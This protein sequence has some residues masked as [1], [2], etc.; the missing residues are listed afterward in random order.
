MS[1]RIARLLEVVT[2]PATGENFVTTVTGTLET[3]PL[4][5]RW[6]QNTVQNKVND[7]ITNR[8]KNGI[9]KQ[10]VGYVIYKYGSGYGLNLESVHVESEFKH[11]PRKWL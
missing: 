6:N 9:L 8:I 7:V 4:D 2:S 10:N 5:N 11:L 3:L 1:K